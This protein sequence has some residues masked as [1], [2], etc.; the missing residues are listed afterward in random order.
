MPSTFP[1]TE[2]QKRS[3]PPNAFQRFVDHA[4][5]LL[6]GGSK[7]RLVRKRG[8][9]TGVCAG[10]G[11]YFEVNPAIFRL[12]FVISGWLSAGVTILVYLGLAFL[13]PK[14]EAETG[15][16]PGGPRRLRGDAAAGSRESSSQP[17]ETLLLCPN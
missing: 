17:E 9:L 10:L 7:G 12:G 8:S 1:M 15:S 14:E 2:L 5:N 16:L 13:L 4:R 11:D 6:H 3:T